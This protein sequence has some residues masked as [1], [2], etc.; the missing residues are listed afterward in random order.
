MSQGKL[1]ACCCGEAM[2]AEAEFER[3]RDR[4]R[5]FLAAIEELET[6]REQVAASGS[7]TQVEDSSSSSSS[8]QREREELDKSLALAIDRLN[9]KFREVAGEL[10]HRISDLSTEETLRNRLKK[11]ADLYNSNRDSRVPSQALKDE[12]ED[13]YY[14]SKL[15]KA[16][17][18]Q[19]PG[20]E[21]TAR[22]VGKGTYVYG[23]KKPNEATSAK[24]VMRP[25]TKEELSQEANKLIS[26]FSQ[27]SSSEL[28]KGVM[29]MIIR[30]L[31]RPDADLGEA[32]DSDFF[33]T[34]GITPVRY[35]HGG[36][37]PKQL[38]QD[39]INGLVSEEQALGERLHDAAL[40]MQKKAQL[41]KEQ[42]AREQ[43][44]T[45]EGRKRYSM[46]VLDANKLIYSKNKIAN[47]A[48]LHTKE[49]VA[50]NEEEKFLHEHMT[51]KKAYQTTMEQLGDHFLPI[52]QYKFL[53]TMPDFRLFKAKN[54]IHW[55]KIEAFLPRVIQF[56][57]D[58][59]IFLGA[60]DK[61]KLSMLTL[62]S[63]PTTVL[64][65]ELDEI[66]V[67]LYDLYRELNN[68]ASA[69]AIQ[70]AYKGYMIRK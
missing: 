33:T 42:Y 5:T 39:Y 31:I 27:L 66:V 25:K 58:R 52:L 41:Q 14:E 65:Y 61:K 49:V 26:D 44:I 17:F 7:S 4:A 29:N 21:H 59:S 67:N 10:S 56:C 12:I 69:T 36:K 64:D 15:P 18:E 38:L 22:V 30:G 40:G 8:G 48:V 2:S 57:K 28:D 24:K 34:M 43:L 45:P 46:K 1:D 55:K 70:A 37:T 53:K 68:E 32:F 6:F 3:T 51:F 20:D 19:Q 63:T 9:A 11:Q 23:K 60:V 54:T 50:L 13:E 62:K 35:A 47:E 16:A